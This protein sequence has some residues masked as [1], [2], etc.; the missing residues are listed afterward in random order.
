MTIDL[1]CDMGEGAGND[2]DLMP[3]VT[4]ANIACGFHASDPATMRCTVRLAR[5]HGVAV[6]AHPS[7]RDREGAGRRPLRLAPEQV[8]DEVTYQVGALL[9]FCRAEG[10]RLTHVKPHGALYNAAA[11]DAALAGAICEAVRAI[12]PSLAMICLAGSRMASIARQVG[13]ACLEEAFADRAYTSAGQLVPRAAPGA[14]I[15]DPEKAA[16]RA[17]MI[18]RDR[19]VISVDGSVIPLAAQTLCVHGDTPGCVP[20]LLA[21]RAGLEAEGIAIR[22]FAAEP[23]PPR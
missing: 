7:Y 4:S 20:L 1:N 19:R 9:A 11:T 22:P 6:G 10:V 5:E 16:Q 21:I 13:L 2:S 18:T 14:V 15:H 3:L 17:V 23:G 8:R 12:D